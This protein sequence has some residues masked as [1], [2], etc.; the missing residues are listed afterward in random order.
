[1]ITWAKVMMPVVNVSQSARQSVQDSE[2]RVDASSITIRQKM[3]STVECLI[4][5]FAPVD[6]EVK[7]V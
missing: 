2:Q 7:N 3:S 5:A 4:D 6:S 1:M